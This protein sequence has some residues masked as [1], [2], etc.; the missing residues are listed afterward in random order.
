MYAHPKQVRPS[1]SG[2]P[3]STCTSPHMYA[4]QCRTRR[5][6]HA[7]AWEQ[8]VLAPH[9]AVR[10][11]GVVHSDGTSGETEARADDLDG[12]A[13]HSGQDN[14]GGGDRLCAA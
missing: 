6:H 12:G 11:P 10:A 4:P 13:T 7:G 8:H 14:H 2:T 3:G 9:H 5:H 1:R